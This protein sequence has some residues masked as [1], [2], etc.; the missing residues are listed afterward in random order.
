[1]QEQNP[2]KPAAPVPEH[3]KILQALAEDQTP[4][5]WT[6]WTDGS[7]HTDGYGGYGAVTIRWASDGAPSVL[8]HASGA[9]CGTTV[10]RAELTGLLEALELIHQHELQLK[11][12]GLSCYPNLPVVVKWYSDRE[13][14][15]LSCVQNKVTG[16]PYYSRRTDADLWARYEWYSK[17]IHVRP[18]HIDRNSMQM[19]AQCDYVASHGRRAYIKWL[20]NLQKRK[21]W[22]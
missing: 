10:N 2:P 9:L 4:V 13:N 7:G 22:F 19:Q 1:M 18:V 5:Q 12:A 16:E 14:L 6:A 8:K 15:V 3:K 11:S 21:K 17:K 20:R